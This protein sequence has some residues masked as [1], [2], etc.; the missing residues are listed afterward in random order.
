MSEGKGA[1]P[2]TFAE[3]TDRPT[4]TALNLWRNPMGNP[5]FGP[6]YVVFAPACASARG[7]YWAAVTAVV[8]AAV[9]VAVAGACGASA[10]AGVVAAV[11]HYFCSCYVA[12]MWLLPVAAATMCCHCNSMSSRDLGGDDADR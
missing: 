8:A 11:C 10:G 12:A 1:L 6:V 2:K 4:Y 3:A 9:A 5:K 7:C